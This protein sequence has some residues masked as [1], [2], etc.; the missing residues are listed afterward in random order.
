MK[1][2]SN[3]VSFYHP[4]GGAGWVVCGSVDG[5]V[6]WYQRVLEL[7]FL[8]VFLTAESTYGVTRKYKIKLPHNHSEGQVKQNS[9]FNQGYVSVRTRSSGPY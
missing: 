2:P 5:V 3:F 7:C 9:K 1:V 6:G 8:L 4:W